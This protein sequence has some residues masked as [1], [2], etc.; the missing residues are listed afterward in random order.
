[1][2]TEKIQTWLINKDR[3]IKLGV[4]GTPEQAHH[5]QQALLTS[6]PGTIPRDSIEVIAP[7]TREVSTEHLIEGASRLEHTQ[8]QRVL[9]LVCSIA[10]ISATLIWPLRLVFISDYVTGEDLRSL[11][12]QFVPVSISITDLCA[13]LE[14]EME[15]ANAIHVVAMEAAQVHHARAK[16]EQQAKD[17]EKKE[18]AQ[19]RYIVSTVKKAL[20]PYITKLWLYRA[21]SLCLFFIVAVGSFSL[22]TAIQHPQQT[23]DLLEKCHRYIPWT[24]TMTKENPPQQKPLEENTRISTGQ[25]FVPQSEE[26]LP[27]TSNTDLIHERYMHEGEDN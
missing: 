23:K 4:I 22:L 17:L 18:A 15:E 3:T 5:I 8:G 20:V 10:D 6:L 7:T 1:M 21:I 24:Q 19:E 11:P 26:E 25:G 2:G 27:S 9:W 16:I 13:T 14:E 12:A